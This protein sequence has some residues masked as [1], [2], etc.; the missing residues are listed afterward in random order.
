MFCRVRMRKVIFWQDL[1]L[2]GHWCHCQCKSGAAS[3][4]DCSIQGIGIHHNQF[5]QE[6]F[7]LWYQW[8]SATAAS[9]SMFTEPDASSSKMLLQYR[10]KWKQIT[11][12]RQITQQKQTNLFTASIFI[13]ARLLALVTIFGEYHHHFQGCTRWYPKSLGQLR[14][15]IPLQHTIASLPTRVQL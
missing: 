7:T 1:T 8:W 13:L 5:R 6:I 2:V 11:Q 10:C 12:L 9:L 15:D 14:I 3:S 4:Q